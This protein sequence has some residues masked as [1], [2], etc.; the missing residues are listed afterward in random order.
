MIEFFDIT[1][2]KNTSHLKAVQTKSTNY[3]LLTA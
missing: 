3:T 1:I 2:D